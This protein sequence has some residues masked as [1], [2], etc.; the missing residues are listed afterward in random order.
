MGELKTKST[1]QS[2]DEYLSLVADEG[3]RADCFALLGLMKDVTREEPKMW[4]S[5]MVGFGRYRYKY[6]SGTS[7]EWFLT[8]FSPRKGKLSLHIMSGV[9]NHAEQLGKLGK[10]ENGKSC[11]HI[12][13]L[14]DVDSTTLRS[15]IEE[16]VNEMRR[17]FPA[18]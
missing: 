1:D 8:G 14:S 4:G 10:Y 5:A 13:R 17:Q 9:G 18:E 6:P 7:G 11:L 15:L 3:Q 16:S 12:K 2:V